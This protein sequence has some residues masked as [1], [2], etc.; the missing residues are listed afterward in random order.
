MTAE[1]NMTS[2]EMEAQV[3]EKIDHYVNAAS[4]HE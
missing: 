3:L 4:N 1:R 2:A